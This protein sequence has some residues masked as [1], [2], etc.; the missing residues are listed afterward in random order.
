MESN[1]VPDQKKGNCWSSGWSPLEL[2]LEL[3]LLSG[4]RYGYGRPDRAG[5]TV[6]WVGGLVRLK[7]G[8]AGL[9]CSDGGR[10]RVVYLWARNANRVG[11]A[12]EDEAAPV[13]NNRV[14]SG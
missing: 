4:T 11:P 12:D 5:L 1:I 13:A 10:Q 9:L 2:E 6:W 7:A 8:Q 3:G 14:V